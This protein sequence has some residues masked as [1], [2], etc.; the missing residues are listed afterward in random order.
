[1][2][3]SEYG[4][5]YKRAWGDRDFKALGAEQQLQYLKLLSQTDISLAG[6]LTLA[7]TRWA[8]QT[9]GLEVADIEAA[10]RDLEAARFII[11]DR[12]TQEVLVRSYIRNDELWKSFK[13]MKAIRG[14][15]E[16]VLSP[17]LKGVISSE[18]LRIDTSGISNRAS[19]SYKQSPREYVEGV[20][21]HLVDENPPLDTP[22][23]TPCHT[24]SDGVSPSGPLSVAPANAPAIAVAPAIATAPRDASHP[25]SEV[26]VAPLRPDI[27]HVLD[28][29]DEALTANGSPKPSRTK[30]NHDAARLLIDKDHHTVEA[31]ERAIDFA[32]NDE[33]W[34]SN[35]LCMSKLR[36]KYEQ[37]RLAAQ[38]TPRRP[39]SPDRQADVLR[40]E[41]EWAAQA[42]AQSEHLQLEGNYS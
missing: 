17:R 28:Y 13:T 4:K 6:V 25:S 11:C 9:S 3:S 1:M 41:M 42:D 38:R 12:D 40:A 24:P 10:L 16:R 29:L 27:E 34:R 22:S 23:D 32:T 39:S 31:I 30:K 2:A 20:I 36:D 15:V 18:L 8:T 19:D 14:A 37:L 35:I 33:F 21:A 7:P 26:A 5:I